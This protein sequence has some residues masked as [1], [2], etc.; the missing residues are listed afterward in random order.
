MEDV[1]NLSFEDAMKEL[2]ELTK[3]LEQGQIPLAEAL[4]THAR[5]TALSAHIEKLLEPLATLG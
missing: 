3:K 2:G 1:A 4:T 5:A